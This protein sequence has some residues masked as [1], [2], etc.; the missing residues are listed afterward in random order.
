VDVAVDP[1]TAFT[2]FTDEIDCWWVRGPVN[3]FD[4]ARAVAMRIE[5]D[6]EGHRWTFAQARPG[7]T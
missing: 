4:A 7:M 1:S 6:L 2:A 5:P 3:F